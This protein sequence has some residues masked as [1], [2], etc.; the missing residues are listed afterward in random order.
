[1]TTIEQ[2]RGWTEEQQD[3]VA[4]GFVGRPWVPVTSDC[5]RLVV[6]FYQAFGVWLP[7]AAWRPSGPVD[8]R[9]L[10]PRV[11]AVRLVDGPP[12]FGDILVFGPPPDSD[13]QHLAVYI[14]RGRALHSGRKTGAA[15]QKVFPAL[16]PRL[17][18]IYRIAAGV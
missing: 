11:A 6:D 1:M 2:A 10:A 16:Q 17:Q 8:L 15:L 13:E 9:T 14:N 4:A 18:A 5:W 12:L 7:F 3:S